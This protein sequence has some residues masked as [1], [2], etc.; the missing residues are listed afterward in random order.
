PPLRGAVEAPPLVPPPLKPASQA[1]LMA[2]PAFEPDPIRPAPVEPRKVPEIKVPEIKAPDVELAPA[3]RVEPAAS[4][5]PAPLADS[6][7]DELA[8][9]LDAALNQPAAKAEPQLSLADLLGESPAQPAEPDIAPK[10]IAPK[11]IA[12]KAEPKAE[13][14]SEPAAE[15]VLHP[16]VAVDSPQV[17]P[18][19]RPLSRFLYQART[20]SE[21]R[22]GTDVRPRLDPL[23]RVERPSE[24]S[25]RPMAPARSEPPLRPREFAFRPVEPA[26][27]EA[28]A[29]DAPRREPPALREITREPAR[30]EPQRPNEAAS[31]ARPE[32]AIEVKPEI[33]SEA[34]A[35]D[36]APVRAGFIPATSPKAADAGT[37]APA[38]EPQDKD[39]LEDFDAE[40]ASLLGRSSARGH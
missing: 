15:P 22:V 21:P 24:D 40:M 30:I 34:K 2:A 39:P 1:P 37:D 33:R 17:R 8:Q 14:K 38:A 31:L 29:L 10:D 25:A 16:D 4:E 32:P 11:D 36:E 3:A 27:R 9:R 12:P 28:P 13:A 18:T 20:R 6:R 19:D 23:P 35:A 5:A 26:N 7:L